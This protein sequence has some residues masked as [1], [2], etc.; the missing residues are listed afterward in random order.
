ML[1]FVS[2]K[3]KKKN[4]NKSSPFCFPKPSINIYTYNTGFHLYIKKKKTLVSWRGSAIIGVGGMGFYS[5]PL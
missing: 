2:L 4:Q 3:K 5:S 1:D